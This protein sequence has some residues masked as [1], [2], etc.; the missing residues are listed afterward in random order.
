MGNDAVWGHTA[1]I[2]S[3]RP[4]PVGRVSPRGVPI[5]VVPLH[6]AIPDNFD[7]APFNQRGGLCNAPQ[8][9]GERLPELL[10]ELNEVLAA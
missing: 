10:V 3:A 7:D 1:Y 4:Q 5:P 8:L 6:G 2:M 9:F